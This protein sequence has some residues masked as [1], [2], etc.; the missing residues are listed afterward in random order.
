MPSR[1]SAAALGVLLVAFLTGCVSIP[2][3]GPVLSYPVTSGPG[4][5]SQPFMQRIPQAPQATWTP[6]EVVQGFI[7]ASGSL[8]NLQQIANE[9]LTSQF[10]KTWNPK[11]SA[12]VYSKGPF[13]APPTAPGGSCSSSSKD[14]PKQRRPQKTAEVE[15][16][17]AV[18]A[19]VQGTGGYA[20]ASAKAP[21]QPE[22]FGL[23]QEAGGAWRINCAPQKLL[24]TSYLFSIDYQQRNLYFFDPKYQVLVPD[25]VYVPLN[26]TPAELMNNLVSD[27]E[28]PPKDWLSGATFTAFPLGT[29]VGDVT[30]DGGTATVNLTGAIAKASPQVLQQ[31][32][33]Q[34]W[35]TLTSSGQANQANQANQAVQSVELVLGGK[36]WIPLNVQQNPVQNQSQYSPP[37]PAKTGVFYYLD[38]AGY[39]VEQNGP[40]GTPRRIGPSIGKG[41]SQIAV[42]PLVG[43]VQYVAALSGGAQASG[44][45]YTG[46]LGGK[47]VKRG[48]GYSSMSWDPNGY[49]WTTSDDQIFRLRG[50]ARLGQS[51]FQPV[52]VNVPNVPT[53]S[54]SFS[55]IRVAPD[56][57]RVA[58]I[59]GGSVLNFGAITSEPGPRSQPDF[60]IVLS[61]FYVA[62]PGTTLTA[63]T[64]YGTDNVITLG[65]PGPVLTEYAVNG[66]GSTSI[67]PAPGAA[68]VTA[69]S[70]WPLIAGVAKDG[71]WSDASQ[72]GAWGPISNANSVPLKGVS[73]VYPG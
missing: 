10:S 25:P 72:T 23:V 28:K 4:G 1:L 41:F 55:A 73:P 22:Y 19:N 16:T 54:G 62:V 60:K 49:L 35:W 66:G 24:L 14:N 48:T 15:V 61:P 18:Q 42:S 50:N 13:V 52:P 64:W 56:G 36:P 31:V 34:L 46:Q 45:L 63:V 39:V 70:G 47:L 17:G 29:D 37:P 65:T 58:I 38:S 51:A 5:Q 30:L 8:G 27:L 33:A 7:T 32:S 9:Y 67:P 53:A 71:M 69:S 6:T 57:V 59:V 68:T 44:T 20:V 43:G 3:G 40:Q 12:T 2:S 21:Q 26:A 11:W